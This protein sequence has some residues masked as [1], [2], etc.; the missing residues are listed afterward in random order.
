[1]RWTRSKAGIVFLGLCVVG[2]VA[3]GYRTATAGPSE[4]PIPPKAADERSVKKG[5]PQA[6][7][8]AAEKQYQIDVELFESLPNGEQKCLAA[9]SLCT[10]EGQTATC[11][12]G[13]EF[14]APRDDGTG[15]DFIRYGVICTTKV[16]KL[17]DGKLRLRG[18]F[19]RST[20]IVP[21]R[22]GWG[23]R[24]NIAEICTT[25]NPGERMDLELQEGG[26]GAPRLRLR[27]TLNL[28][29]NPAKK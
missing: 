9:P 3:L 7:P 21:M 29:T 5:P 26:Q 13:G 8:K 28:V 2:L 15:V 14:P 12:A 6:A 4:P 17:R 16:S 10:L 18:T 22:D 25:V 19:E 27:L 23:I 24:K 11:H 1:M 20:R